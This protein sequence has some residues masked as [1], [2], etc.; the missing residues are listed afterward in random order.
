MGNIEHDA[1]EI[2]GLIADAARSEYLGFPKVRDAKLDDA[3]SRLVGLFT[4][5]RGAVDALRP[6][7]E[8]FDKTGRE[9]CP[10]FD[11]PLDLEAFNRAA[12]IVDGGQ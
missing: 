8:A 6:F 2:V 1:R 5:D 9:F 3:A 12:R 11:G 7:V 10:S 4:A